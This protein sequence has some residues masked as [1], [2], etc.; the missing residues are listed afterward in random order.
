MTAGK[1]TFSISNLTLVMSGKQKKKSLLIHAAAR[2]TAG[3]VEVL[4]R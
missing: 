2:Q 4:K 1:S 3:D